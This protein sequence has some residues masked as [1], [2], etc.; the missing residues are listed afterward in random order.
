MQLGYMYLILDIIWLDLTGMHLMTSS[1]QELPAENMDISA[2]L[3]ASLLLRM[4]DD[5]ENQHD[6]SA[7]GLRLSV[8]L[9]CDANAE[10]EWYKEHTKKNRQR[11]WV[12][13]A[14]HSQGYPQRPYCFQTIHTEEWF[15]SDRMTSVQQGR[16]EWARTIRQSQQ[17][18]S[19]HTQ[20]NDAC[21]HAAVIIYGPF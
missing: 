19:I 11:Q 4:Q 7:S 20:R 5:F 1:G 16:E 8:L 21:K 10:R 2:R 17:R 13:L 6:I 3:R 15:T 9:R 18:Y 12:K 14:T